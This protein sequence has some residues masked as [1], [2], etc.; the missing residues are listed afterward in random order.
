MPE[1]VLGDSVS[2]EP[3]PKRRRTD[4]K[5]PISFGRAYAQSATFRTLFK[6][7]MTLVEETADY[8]DGDGR[9]ESRLDSKRAT[10]KAF[11]D[12]DALLKKKD[13]K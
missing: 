11:A 6:E 12:L 4:K 9:G 2:V 5:E 7:G 1:S 10:Y 3:N 8:L 13:R